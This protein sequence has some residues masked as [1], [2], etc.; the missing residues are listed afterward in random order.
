MKRFI[1]TKLYRKF[2]WKTSSNILLKIAKFFYCLN[3]SN[4]LPDNT[5]NSE[6]KEIMKFLE[7]SEKIKTKLQFYVKTSFELYT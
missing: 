5:D 4:N 1:E 7:K 3:K 6:E 2:V